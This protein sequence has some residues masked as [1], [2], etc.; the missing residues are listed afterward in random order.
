MVIKWTPL[1]VQSLRDIF[2]FYVP[3]TGHDKALQIVA[4]LRD[5]TRYLLIFPE[6]GRRESIEGI[7]KGYRSIIKD[8]FKIYYTIQSKYILISLVWDTRRNPN[9]LKRHLHLPH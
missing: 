6:M 4:A 8:N 5:E 7:D 2:D 9:L 3:Q 1:A